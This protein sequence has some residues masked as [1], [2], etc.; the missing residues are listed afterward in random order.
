MLVSQLLASGVGWDEVLGRCSGGLTLLHR[1]VRSG[2]AGMVQLVVA[3]GEAHGTPFDWQVGAAV[4]TE[5]EQQQ[6][7][8]G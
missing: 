4:G 3:L 6:K 2:H 8:L 1:A 5:G 7:Q